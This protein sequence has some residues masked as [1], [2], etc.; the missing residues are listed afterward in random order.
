MTTNGGTRTASSGEIDGRLE[1]ESG[2][3]GPCWNG[4]MR[5]NIRNRRKGCFNK[6]PGGS[7]QVKPI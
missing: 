6:N 2:V 3:G 1:R 7:L 5:S 4:T